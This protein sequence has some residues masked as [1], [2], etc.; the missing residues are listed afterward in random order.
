MYDL[1]LSKVTI[2]AFIYVP[3]NLAT[4]IFGMNISQL[5]GQ[6]QSIEAFVHTA[7]VISGVTA[8]C[9]FISSQYEGY[10][11]WNEKTRISVHDSKR[12]SGCSLSARVSLLLWLL[13]NGHSAWAWSNKAWIGLLTNDRYGQFRVDTPEGLCDSSCHYV[14]QYIANRKSAR[15]GVPKSRKDRVRISKPLPRF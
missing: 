14:T 11:Q 3:L 6:G 1:T 8:M 9:W 13:W 12:A 10:R 2:L 4:S 5:N 7:L 15:A